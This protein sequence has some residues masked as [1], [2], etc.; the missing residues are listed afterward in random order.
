MTRWRLVALI[1]AAAVIGFGILI[2]ISAWRS[3][4]D[5]C[6]QAWATAAA[7]ETGLRGALNITAEPCGTE[8]FDERFPTFPS[9]TTGQSSDEQDAFEDETPWPINNRPTEGPD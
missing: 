3:N 4:N 2:G 8:S 5:P 6:N 7:A 9:S 1:A